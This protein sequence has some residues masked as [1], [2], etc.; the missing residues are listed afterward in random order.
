M[1]AIFTPVRTHTRERKNDASIE[2]IGFLA[3]LFGC[4]HEKTS[5]PFTTESESYRVCTSCGA[6]RNF[7]PETL[8][9]SGKFYFPRLAAASAKVSADSPSYKPAS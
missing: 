4:W 3:S 1:E 7:N 8:E 9:T 5:R 2:E 6:H